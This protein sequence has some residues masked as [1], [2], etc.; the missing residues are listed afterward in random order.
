M[1]RTRRTLSYPFIQGDDNKL[2]NKKKKIGQVP[3]QLRI[4]S[5]SPGFYK[6]MVTLL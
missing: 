3:F 1:H 5:G 6:Q 4:Y 2:I